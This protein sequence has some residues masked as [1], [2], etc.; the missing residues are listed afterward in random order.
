[1]TV[2]R[3]FMLAF[4]LSL[5]MSYK[6]LLMKVCE[7]GAVVRSGHW[8]NHKVN[9]GQHGVASEILGCVSC[10]IFSASHDRSA[11]Y[12]QH[13]SCKGGKTNDPLF[14]DAFKAFRRQLADVS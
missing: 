14:I 10:R 13:R 5:Q 3:L 6:N 11:F 4:S 9:Q 1:M 8:K 7:C 2:N 12:E